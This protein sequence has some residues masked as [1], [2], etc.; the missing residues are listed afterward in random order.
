[1]RF[2]HWLSYEMQRMP[3]RR[4]PA[5]LQASVLAE[6]ARRAARPWWQRHFLQWPLPA[7]VAFLL[8][9]VLVTRL[10]LELGSWT[11][12]ALATSLRDAREGLTLLS[13]FGRV[14]R[15]LIEV[16]PVDILYGTAGLMVLLYGALLALGAVAYRTFHE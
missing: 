8:L 7:R 11:A 9:S 2:A 6:L 16:V 15:A 12:A 13:A 14:G 5:T 10:A 1:M 3:L 4:A